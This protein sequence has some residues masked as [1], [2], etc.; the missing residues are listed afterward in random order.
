MCFKKFHVTTDWTAQTGNGFTT[1]NT[2]PLPPSTYQDQQIIFEENWLVT[3]RLCNTVGRIQK[4]QGNKILSA[5]FTE[6]ANFFL[7]VIHKNF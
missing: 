4:E 2:Q 3:T 6:K 5:S 1:Y 7:S